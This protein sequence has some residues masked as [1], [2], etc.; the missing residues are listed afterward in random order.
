MS[1][2]PPHLRAVVFDVFGTLLEIRAPLR[3]YSRLIDLATERGC[4]IDRRATAEMLMSQPLSLSQVA[5]RLR[6]G[7]ARSEIAR[8]NAQLEEELAS[9]S[10][11]ADVRPAL[12]RLRSMG[13]KIAVCSNLAVPYV[14]P[15]RSLLGALV[16]VTIWSC[17]VGSLKP[18]RAIFMTALEHLGVPAKSVLMV[19]DSMTADIVG[20][21]S[22]GMLGLLLERKSQERSAGRINSLLDLVN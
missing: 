9:I 10:L 14:Q 20:A 17:E 5:E 8:L 16:D 15:A 4:V 3:P 22:A 7:I 21:R 19:G 1:R 13:L 12:S 18:S 2:M 11:F 6:L